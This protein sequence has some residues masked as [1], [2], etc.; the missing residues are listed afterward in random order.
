MKFDKQIEHKI[1]LLNEVLAD[2][3]QP[4]LLENSCFS[5]GDL[6]CEFYLELKLESLSKET[7]SMEI[8]V[9]L[10][11]LQIGLDRV[12][13][14]YE[15]SNDTIIKER[16]EISTLIKQLLTSPILVEYCGANYTAFSVFDV[17]G[18]I[19]FKTPIIQGLYFKFKCR[20]KLFDPI[21][22]NKK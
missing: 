4:K 21:Y 20:E 7:I 16:R 12:S 15:W 18:N 22:S 2:L 10:N 17:R 5:V 6:S 13:E 3:N 1:D 19:A 9:S 11:D 8:R 14:V